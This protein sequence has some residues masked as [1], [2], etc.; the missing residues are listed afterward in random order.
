MRR[1]TSWKKLIMSGTLVLVII[2]A[3]ETLIVLGVSVSELVI[4][5]VLETLIVVGIS[6]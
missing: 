1:L 2:S 5:V 3:G 4:L 6:A